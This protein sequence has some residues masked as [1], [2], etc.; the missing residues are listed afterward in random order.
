M[1]PEKAGILLGE[2]VMLHFLDKWRWCPAGSFRRGCP[3]VR[4]LDMV[5]LASGYAVER[6]AKKILGITKF[7]SVGERRVRFEWYDEKIDIACALRESEFDPMVLFYT[8]SKDFNIGM[9][10]RAKAM[11]YKLNEY[12]L[13][14]GEHKWVHKVE[15]IF[16]TL[17]MDFVNPEERS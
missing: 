13:W 12:G 9:R 5:V 15:D 2:M 4:D 17:E 3:E 16:E 7:K 1:R 10:K 8:G 11:G 14:Y 6:R